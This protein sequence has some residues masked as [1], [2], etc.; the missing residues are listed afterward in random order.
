VSAGNYSSG[1]LSYWGGRHRLDLAV[2]HGGAYT[3]IVLFGDGQGLFTRRIEY[4]GDSLPSCVAIADFNGDRR[5]DLIAGNS[6]SS[7]A[8]VMLNVCLP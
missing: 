5:L 7:S 4:A 2:G 8:S 3:V 1:R 6:G